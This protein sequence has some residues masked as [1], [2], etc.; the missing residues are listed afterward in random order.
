MADPFE[1]TRTW[2]APLVGLILLTPWFVHADKIQI[3]AGAFNISAKTERGNGTLSGIGGYQINYQKAFA[4]RFALSLGYSVVMSEVIGGDMGFGFDLGFTYYPFSQSNPEKVE[5]V[6]GTVQIV[7]LW[8]P[9]AGLGFQERRFQSIEANFSGFNLNLGVERQ[10]NWHHTSAL[11]ELRYGMMA[12]KNGS[13]AD[14]L[15]V[16]AGLSVP[17]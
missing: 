15:L 2:I 10:L 9:Y 16:L 1:R 14:E 8:R 11:F 3:K 13:T 4:G 6:G 12:G 17:F 7:D 5:S